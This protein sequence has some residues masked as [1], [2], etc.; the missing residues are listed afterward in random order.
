MASLFDCFEF[1][2]C[3][4]LTVSFSKCPT[5]SYLEIL[6][7]FILA[8]SLLFHRWFDPC[9]G[10]SPTPGTGIV[11]FFRILIELAWFTVELK[12]TLDN[13]CM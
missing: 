11:D 12:L 4:L 2:S 5:D 10:V 6:P 1:A 7:G 9:P 13:K 3:D 8:Y